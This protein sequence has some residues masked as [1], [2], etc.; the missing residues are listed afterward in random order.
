MLETLQRVFAGRTGA[1][2]A[3]DALDVAIVAYVIYRL[4][5][6]VRGTRAMQMGTGLGMV[7]LLYLVAKTL[8]LVTLQSLLSYVLSSLILIVVVVFQNDI[9]RALIRVGGAFGSHA[10]AG[11][12][13]PASSTRWSRPSPSSRAIASAPS[14]LSSKTPTSSSSPS[15]RASR[16]VPSSRASSW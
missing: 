7:F 8:E 13:S 15:P 10:G 11:K 9:R 3:R 16:S 2:L 6:I 4:L 5:L 14:S 1:D 12:S